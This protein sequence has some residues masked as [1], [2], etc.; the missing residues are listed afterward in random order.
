MILINR[1]QTKKSENPF[2]LDEIKRRAAENRAMYA[3]QYEAELAKV[4]CKKCG[5]NGGY[6]ER[7]ESG[8]EVYR[9]CPCMKE[10]KVEGLF[11]SSKI[12]FAF[13][14][15]SFDGFSLGDRPDIVRDAYHM[16][17]AYVR[18][19]SFIK[20]DRKNSIALLGGPGSGKTHL[21]TAV[22]NELID[23]GVGV[24]YFPFVQGFNELKDDWDLV[25]G[26]V[27]KLQDAEVLF[28]DDLW[29]GRGEPTPFQIEQMYAVINERYLQHKPILI[30]SERS[31]DDMIKYDE[32]LGSRIFEMTND[33]R[34]ALKGGRELNYRLSEGK[35]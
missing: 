17:R 26:R 16:A 14:K 21:L 25:H 12:T 3:G 5:D 11:E 32:A 18:D 27:Q 24:L 34:V 7:L 23:A 33:Y 15:L 2:D 31:I 9:E 30:S 29:K 1:P 6:A 19:F 22:A 4:R 8:L 35:P 10:R 13:R 28:I 20:G